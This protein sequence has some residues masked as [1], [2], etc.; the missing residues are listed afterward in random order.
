MWQS[1]ETHS[2]P[3]FLPFFSGIWDQITKQQDAELYFSSQGGH[4]T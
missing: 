2:A 1:D 3:L 4:S